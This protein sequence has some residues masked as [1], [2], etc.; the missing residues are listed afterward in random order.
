MRGG[1]R[2]ALWLLPQWAETLAAFL[3]GLAFGAAL[4]VL[5]IERTLP[6]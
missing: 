1:P 4:A 5:A 2:W 6:F 3:T